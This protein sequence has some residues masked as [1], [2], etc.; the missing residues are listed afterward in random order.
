MG[1]SIKKVTRAASTAV[2]RV[3]EAAA[4]VERA[5]R[6]EAAR[7]A[8]R[9]AAEAKEAAEELARQVE[10]EA[11]R[12]AEALAEQARK[13]EEEARKAVEAIK[14][15]QAEAE[16]LALE[17]AQKA[18]EELK[19]QAETVV[20]DHINQTLNSVV[21]DIE[22][23][24]DKG[25][26]FVKQ[27][28]NE[29]QNLIELANI[30]ALKRK[31]LDKAEQLSEEY[32]TNKIQP[33][34]QSIQLAAVPDVKLDLQETEIRVELYIYFLLLDDKDKDPGANAIAVLTTNLQ[35]TITKLTVPDVQ[36]QFTFNKDKLE[37][38]LQEKIQKR[39]EKEKDEL[40]KGFLKSFFSDYVAV[41]EKIMAY[42]PK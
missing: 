24:T 26:M 8:E 10:E 36:A 22:S 5:A 16:R 4:A 9:A 2:D 7:A 41:F 32:L 19:K 23:F 14:A 6:E 31:L 11:K 37:A 34:A 38:S 42:L 30:D 12:Q 40:I 3:A 25:Q 39:I 21:G 29:I 17:T 20:K 33:L 13:T 28:Q 1:L 18:V 15:A 27:I 35:Q